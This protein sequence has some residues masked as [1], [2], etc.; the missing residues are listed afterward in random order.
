MFLCR[1][2]DCEVMPECYLLVKTEFKTGDYERR[3]IYFW[4][5]LIFIRSMR[6]I[7]CSPQPL[8][9]CHWW[10]RGN[11]KHSWHSLSITLLSRQKKTSQ[12]F[13]SRERNVCHVFGE[14]EMMEE[15]RHGSNLQHQP[16]QPE[17]SPSIS[18]LLFRLHFV[19][20]R[21]CLLFL[22]LTID[23]GPASHIWGMQIWSRSGWFADIGLPLGLQNQ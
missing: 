18:L 6:L 5:P 16:S 20:P 11:G 4:W 23:A 13:L 9:T 21:L 14:I 8:S 10:G 19:L 12:S 15:S 3:K 1:I 2:K 17:S 7:C 22:T